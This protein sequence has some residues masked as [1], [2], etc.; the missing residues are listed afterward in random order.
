MNVEIVQQKN[1]SE[2][3]LRELWEKCFGDSKAYEDF[4]FQTVYPKNQ[5]YQ[6]PDKG[7]VHLNP[8]PCQIGEE[9]EILYYIVAVATREDCR[10]QGIMRMLLVRVLEDMHCA[11]LPFTYLM[12]ADTKYYEPFDF[13]S[14]CGEEKDILKKC[15][16]DN[17]NAEGIIFADYR[18]L[19]Q[20]LTKAEW[21]VLSG[22][23]HY[24]LKK[25]YGIFAIHDKAYFD[26][27]CK[28]KNCQ[29]GAVVF[30]FDCRKKEDDITG[31]F[32]GFF[33]YGKTDEYVDVEQ[34]VFRTVEEMGDVAE[35]EMMR[36][37]A[38]IYFT[39]ALPVHIIHKFPY[40]FRV[41]DALRCMELF[42]DCFW[43]Y[44]KDNGKIYVKDDIVAGN[45]GI[46]RFGMTEG[47]V[48]VW[49]ENG[50]DWQESFLEET[51]RMD[52]GKVMSVKELSE[53]ILKNYNVFFAEVV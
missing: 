8:Y 5:V 10:R 49:K 14:I 37:V 23:L 48:R 2:D 45:N 30:C 6:V 21:D 42:S 46:Y 41:V 25:R 52:S 40:M 26:L 35:K 50:Q 4:Y 7:M 31:S 24:W 51:H 18:Q 47:T 36:K 17:L 33:A 38:A 12:P 9:M 13:V 11:G 15:E 43:D 34:Y 44:A 16:Y 29:E 22:W 32:L 3:F 39:D 27:L 20:E 28:E 19:R 1:E 53:Y